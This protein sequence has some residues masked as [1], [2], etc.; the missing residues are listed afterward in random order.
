MASPPQLPERGM[1]PAGLGRAV[2]LVERRGAAAQLCVI[3]G[4]ETVLDHAVGCAP[5][6][7]F[8]TFSAS[9]PYTA[10]LI[11]RL[12]ERGALDLDAPITDHWPEFGRH[13]KAGITLR[14]V[15]QHRSGL[16]T[17]GSALGD[18]L[19]MTDWAR[20]ASRIANARRRW[21]VD[22]VP[23]YQY[24][25][26]GFLLGEVAQRATGTPFAELFRTEL[27]DRLGV[28]DTHLGLPDTEW[29]R[30]VPLHGSLPTRVV[31]RRS[32]RRAV[33]PSAGVSTTARDL[34]AFYLAL[35]RD[36]TAEEAAPR[37]LSPTALRTARTPS[38]DGELDRFAKAPI[39][40]S[41]G[42]QLGGPRSDPSRVGPM[43]RLSSRRAFG[44]N[45]SNCCI[46]WAD[47]DRDLVV[48]YLTNRMTGRRAD[49]VHLAAVA[50]E[51]IGA[52][53][54]APGEGA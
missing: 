51:I 42:F 31:N 43:G 44:H 34:A 1:D 17:G 47:P 13:D 38:S 39:R 49:L 10:V 24:L 48:A 32:T 14:H 19:T 52:C 3:R 21:P 18:V 46:A 25:I 6:G 54:D 23:A 5:D 20:S 8:W 30:H 11:H 4:G 37:I 40:W 35:L 22:S 27:L 2:E 36:D 45:G 12:A 7:L 15:L 16:A 29:P 33:I 28:H 26:F 9:K 41:Q 53:A 50:D